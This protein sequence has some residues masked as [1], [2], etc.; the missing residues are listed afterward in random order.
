MA[1][2]L[3][4]IFYCL[5]SSL[6]DKPN[7][8]TGSKTF[9][10]LNIYIPETGS[11][12]FKCCWLD[13]WMDDVSA[14]APA[15]AACRV[16]SNFFNSASAD[17]V[18]TASMGNSGENLPTNLVVDLTRVFSSQFPSNKIA[19]PFS[20]SVFVSSSLTQN[21]TARIGITYE[22]DDAANRRIKTV[23]IPLETTAS[24]TL[25]TPI[26]IDS[27][28]ALLTYC[29]EANKT[30]RD[31]TLQVEGSDNRTASSTI[32]NITYALQNISR[33]IQTT[34]S[35]QSQQFHTYY[36]PYN[37]CNPS[38][39]GNLFFRT[40]TA[41]SANMPNSFTL[42]ATYEYDED[43]SDQILNSVYYGGDVQ[44]GY[45]PV[46]TK[47][48]FK[49]EFVIEEPGPITQSN[50][51]VYHYFIEGVTTNLTT[52]VTGSRVK[53]ITMAHPIATQCGGMAF[54]LRFNSG[55]RQRQAITMSRGENAIVNIVKSNTDTHGSRGNCYCSYILL[56]YLSGKSSQP[57][58][59]ANHSQTR[60]FYLTGSNKTLT[61][62]YQHAYT[63][64]F[65]IPELNYYVNGNIIYGNL[66]INGGNEAATYTIE[67]SGSSEIFSGSG[68]VNAWAG[69][70]ESDAE[71][72]YNRVVIPVRNI[73]KTYPQ[74]TSND[75]LELGTNRRIHTLHGSNPCFWSA[76]QLVSYRTITYDIS[77]SVSGYTG[78]GSG[79][80]VN[81]FRDDD[82]RKVLSLTT[83]TGGAFASKWYYNT[84]PVYCEAFQD[85]THLGRSATV[86]ASGNP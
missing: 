16:S 4:T 7:I 78:D 23:A 31:I 58:G 55:S 28:P 24:H 60:W 35:L 42:F 75:L 27:I 21:H 50:C 8:P 40:D 70:I 6:S 62:D 84:I 64:S 19:A 76:W 66:R 17:F 41:V 83:S 71:I 56:N 43:A 18:Y 74:N 69:I 45:I 32:A 11:R 12:V 3:K 79:I 63:A 39:S 49:R 72:G 9:L 59:S 10:P 68:W 48:A 1:T 80:A 65:D 77:G 85:D 36:F 81:V 22:W 14:T 33:S 26:F 30:F 46:V 54:S 37:E 15:F 82:K 13:M 34:G 86:A 52:Y 51:G 67:A 73:F 5:S 53:P 44:Y 29:P 20:C 61:G 2:R 47:D 38:S 25:T 57:G